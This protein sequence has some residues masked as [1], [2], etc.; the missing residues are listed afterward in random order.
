MK[1][2]GWNSVGFFVFLN[3]WY[4][5]V[6]LEIV[7]NEDRVNVD[8]NEDSAGST[9]GSVSTEPYFKL[10]QQR[11]AILKKKY[12]SLNET[13]KAKIQERARA[14]HE[15]MASLSP[16]PC[17][18]P[19][20]E[21]PHRPPF[22]FPPGG[23]R[24]PPWV[25]QRYRQQQ[26]LPD[27]YTRVIGPRSR[28][29]R[30]A[31]L[32]QTFSVDDPMEWWYDIDVGKENE[33][34]KA[35]KEWNVGYRAH[36]GIEHTLDHYAFPL[37]LGGIDR[38]R[39]VHPELGGPGDR[40]FG[41]NPDFHERDRHAFKWK[42]RGQFFPTNWAEWE[43]EWGPEGKSGNMPAHYQFIYNPHPGLRDN[44]KAI[45]Q[46]SDD[47]PDWDP[48]VDESPFLNEQFYGHPW[49]DLN[50]DYYTARDENLPA[51]SYIM[52]HLQGWRDPNYPDDDGKNFFNAVLKNTRTGKF[53]RVMHADLS[54]LQRA[55]PH[56]REGTFFQDDFVQDIYGSGHLPYRYPWQYDDE[57]GY[58][59]YYRY[60]TDGNDYGFF[61][62]GTY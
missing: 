59:D 25:Q 4:G 33:V 7:P 55:T 52:K 2:F 28:R 56:E 51:G 24:P 58:P 61:G 15:K 41:F 48:M 42:P 20:P 62:F 13:E 11:L 31:E 9:N 60:G 16:P 18:C 8:L 3:V 32:Q 53:Y 43:K 1:Y 21:D 6:R 54:Q 19:E 17:V 40:I 27:P 23:L 50:D 14:F 44:I 12:D 36:E 47:F 22:P 5:F 46:A 26:S 39:I 35:L 10:M 29:R 30:H 57:G 49:D 38:G 37:H 45:A 34:S